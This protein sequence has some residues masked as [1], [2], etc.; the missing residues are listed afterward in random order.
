MERTP[1]LG[2]GTEVSGIKIMTD[3]EVAGDSSRDGRGVKEE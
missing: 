2:L 1:T 3:P